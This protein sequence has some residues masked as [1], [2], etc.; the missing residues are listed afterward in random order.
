MRKEEIEDLG[1]VWQR[2]QGDDWLVGGN[3]RELA[4]W[5]EMRSRSLR[6]WTET[7]TLPKILL[8]ERDP[9]LFLASF[10]AACAANCPVFL[11]N[12]DWAAAEWNQVL[13]L[14]QPDL[15]WKEGENIFSAQTP[16]SFTP[17]PPLPLHCSTASAHIFIPTGGSS[18]QVRFAMHSWQ[19][20]MAAVQGFQQYFGVDRVDSCCGLPLYHV[21]GLMQFLR[22]FVSGGQLA[23]APFRALQ[24]GQFPKI[25]PEGWYL[26]LVPTQLQRLLNQPELTQWLARFQMVLLGGA[27]AWQEL[28]EKARYHQ[29]RLAPTYGMTETAAQIATLKPEAFLRGKTGAGQ[30]LPHAEVQIWNEQG[31]RLATHQVGLITIRSPSLAMGYYPHLFSDPNFFQTDDLGY[32]DEWGNLHIVGHNSRKIITG[33]ENV[34]P[35]E[36]EAAIWATG[37]V[38]DVCVLG[39][40]DFEWGEVVTAIY[41]PSQAAMTIQDLRTA[42]PPKLSKYKCPKHWIAVS[43]I[44][45]SENGKLNYEQ[46]LDWSISILTTP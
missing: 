43:S 6:R 12:P 7:G 9:V 33:G 2:R 3:H 38:A 11:A 46:L 8:V 31:D 24:A 25:E 39:V 34:F 29:I 13:A 36:V 10:V 28:L 35:A 5:V 40:P 45:R 4:G 26:S 42:L 30:V 37:W 23:I 41:V 19:S 16:Q 15:V 21:S 17:P 1:Q 20:L 32:L 14:V 18:G 27:P 44:P 22:S